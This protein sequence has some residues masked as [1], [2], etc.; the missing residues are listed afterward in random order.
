M[1]DKNLALMD[2]IMGSITQADEWQEIQLHDPIIT[3][4]TTHWNAMMEQ[5]EAFLPEDLY[6]DLFDAHTDTVSAIGDAGILFGI[7]AVAAIR[8]VASRP[9]DLSRRILNR[10]EGRK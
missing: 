2:E 5:A 3:A 6:S 10:M 8:D 1:S 9:F 4:A 7:H